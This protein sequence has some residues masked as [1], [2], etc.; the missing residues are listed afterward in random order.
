MES[1]WVTNL[2][3][4]LIFSIAVLIAVFIS[5]INQLLGFR[6][7]RPKFQLKKPDDIPPYLKKLYA[8]AVKQLTPLGF[9]IQHCQLS[10]DIV[11]HA[12]GAKWNLIL[13]HPD[14]HVFAEISPASTSLDMPGYEVNFWSIAPDGN[15]LL[16]M[17]GRGH[18]VM[19]EI[20]GVTVHDPLVQSLHQQYDIHLEERREWSSTT[21]YQSLNPA[22][23]VSSQQKLME[24]YF[25]NLHHARG[26]K[27]TTDSHYRLSLLKCLIMVFPYFKGELRAKKL[28]KTRFKSKLKNKLQGTASKALSSA[29]YPVESDIL[30]FKRLSAVHERH[31][32]SLFSRF[33]LIA[34]TWL[35]AYYALD[36]TFTFH[37]LLILLGVILLH[38]LGHIL[39]MIVFGYREL[40][41]LFVPLFGWARSTANNRA[42]KWKQVMV[43]LMGPLPGI[44]LGI[45]LIV[46]NKTNQLPFLYETAVILLLVNYLHLLP[47]MSL[48]G[49]RIMRLLMMERFPGSK[50][51]FPL[52]SGALFAAGGYY[53]GE[54]VFWA[55][56]M[57]IV[58][59]IPFG[60]RQSAVLRALR[61]LLKEQRKND[62]N[63]REFHSLD[64]NNKLAR[65]FLAL[66][67][68]RFRKLNFLMKYDLVRSLIGVIDQP[69]KSGAISS[70]SLMLIYLTAL[71]VTPQVTLFV[72][73][74]T[75]QTPQF[76]SKYLGV[77][78]KT[79]LESKITRAQSD[80]QRF[81]LLL[82]AADKALHN[83]DLVKVKN[84]LTRA[85]TT[86]PKLGDKDNEQAR[87]S[88]RYAIYYLRNNE[89][90]KATRYQQKSIAFYQKNTKI[91]NFQLAV[92]YQ[93]LS[94]IQFQ[95][96]FN[97]DSEISLQKAL[98]YAIKCKNPKQWYMI[99]TLS[100]QLL[101]WYY[102]EN[103]QTDAQKLLSSLIDRFNDPHE[104]AKSY[105]TRFV[106]EELGWLHAAANDEKA[107]MEKFDQAL[108]MAEHHRSKSGADKTDHVDETKLILAKAAVY[109][110]E[111]YNDFSR[112]QFNNAEELAKQN[113]FPSLEQYINKYRP[114]KRAVA[115]NKEF[116]RE[117]KRWKLISEAFANTHS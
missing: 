114:K 18:T 47:Y 103:R 52:A 73:Q 38:E 102:L 72:A 62:K 19:S 81:D 4:I 20:P 107:A 26:L 65:V 28:L 9:K 64:S 76:R 75:G 67:K 79:D 56:A 99:T 13:C 66:K 82:H 33:M 25:A 83:N 16:T 77:M 90:E 30:A 17:N 108:A 43:Y 98:S 112:I 117:M 32:P 109:Y 84:Y 27:K 36:L 58:A 59:S 46:I 55:L 61:R 113:A 86:L 116:R 37:S 45:T 104:P 91:D 68:P 42:A 44:V 94:Q 10:Q 39:T 31:L 100:G 110:K 96:Q 71:I 70:L 14:T 87:L 8:D 54:P 88:N 78:V 22:A 11:A 74:Q 29:D 92:A 95:Q 41:I 80:Q 7:Q 21:N 34:V 51:L 69:K 89:L 97:Y 53:L 6:I 12:S 111:G 24:G 101:D 23:F 93:R 1:A 48:D 5:E 3:I 40:Q 15:A 50:L 35:I 106:Y 57:M 105:V 115:A 49:G 60:M 2:Q 85:Q 63:S